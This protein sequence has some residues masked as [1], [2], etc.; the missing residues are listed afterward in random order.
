MRFPQF[1]GIL[2]ILVSPELFSFRKAKAVCYM[3]V[4]AVKLSGGNAVDSC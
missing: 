3:R 2:T 4:I 1:V